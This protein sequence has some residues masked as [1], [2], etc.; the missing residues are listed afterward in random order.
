[1]TGEHHT[2]VLVPLLGLAVD[3]GAQAV[4]CRLPIGVGHVRRQFA[5]FGLGLAS[6]AA[7]LA[8]V[9]RRMELG[10]SDLA[11]YAFLSILTY[12]FVGFCF[13]NLINLNVSSLRIRMIREIHRHHPEP[14]PTGR[15]SA[16]YG[17]S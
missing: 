15:L 10:P 7:A 14:V 1:M 17:V 5:S 13:F 11:G 16:L 12:A 2:L 4:L 6:S 8:L 9:L 3:I